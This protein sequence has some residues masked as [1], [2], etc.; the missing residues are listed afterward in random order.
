M[1]VHALQGH[2]GHRTPVPTLVRADANYCAFVV[3]QT[4]GTSSA[5]CLA[6]DLLCRGHRKIHWSSSRQ[7]AN[8]TVPV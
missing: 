8:G 1:R 2:G 5:W 3:E 6:G 4:S 7:V